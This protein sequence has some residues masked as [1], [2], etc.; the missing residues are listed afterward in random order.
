MYRIAIK[1]LLKWKESPRRKPL[2]IEGARQ[3]G[4]IY[5]NNRWIR[6]IPRNRIIRYHKK[7][8]CKRRRDVCLRQALKA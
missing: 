4:F 2:I 6:L 7:I 8:D 1:K 5:I 3:V